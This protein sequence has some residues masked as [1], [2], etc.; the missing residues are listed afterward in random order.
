MALLRF[1]RFHRGLTRDYVSIVR[2]DVVLSCALIAHNA[3][4][5][6]N[7]RE[8]LYDFMRV[9]QICGKLC[10]MH[11]AM[12]QLR[13][14]CFRFCRGVCSANAWYRTHRWSL[15]CADVSSSFFLETPTMIFSLCSKKCLAPITSHLLH[16][17]DHR[18]RIKSEGV[19]EATPLRDVL[20]IKRNR[21]SYHWV[22]CA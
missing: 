15:G 10:R 18:L 1:Y 14:R 2:T 9:S 17:T 13:R 22:H 3:D 12:Q 20:L 16:S 5:R 4:S 7:F 6:V 19:H 21:F 8:N 11:L